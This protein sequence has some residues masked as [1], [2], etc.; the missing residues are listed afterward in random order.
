[1]LSS[2]LKTDLSKLRES[3]PANILSEAKKTYPNSNKLTDLSFLVFLDF[4]TLK[5]LIK[6]CLPIFFFFP[7]RYGILVDPIQV[8]SLF[9]KDPYSWPAACLIIGT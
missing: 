8:V 9:L 4:R 7:P 6:R 1:M 3:N 5:V 2:A